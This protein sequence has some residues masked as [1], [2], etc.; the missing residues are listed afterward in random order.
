MKNWLCLGL[1]SLLLPCRSAADAPLDGT[2]KWNFSL[3]SGDLIDTR[4]KLKTEGGKLTGIYIGRNNTEMPIENLEFKEGTLSFTVNRERNGQK[5]YTK[6]EGKLSGDTNTIKGKIETNFGGEVR[7]RDWVAKRDTGQADVTGTWTY[8][9]TTQ[10]GQSFEPRLRLKQEG[11]Q[12]TGIIIFNENEAPISAGK[13]KADQVTFEIVRERD[14]QTF[15]TKYEGKVT[16]NTVK[17]KIQS[18]WGGQDR[19]YEWDAKRTRQ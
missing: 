16:G 14:G 13:V 5:T 10:S 9:F 6:H 17:G 3:P 19:T 1:L 12:V 2:W 8:T 15:T 11:D 7:T 18:N 4:L